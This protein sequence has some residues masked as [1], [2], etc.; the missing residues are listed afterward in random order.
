MGNKYLTKQ[1]SV[2]QQNN[3][4]FRPSI[5]LKFCCIKLFDLYF[6]EAAVQRYSVKTVFLGLRPATLLK[7][8]LQH[9]CFPV[10]FAKFLRTPFFKEHLWWLL[11][12]FVL[13]PS[14]GVRQGRLGI[15]S[16]N[17]PTTVS[18]DVYVNYYSDMYLKHRFIFRHR[19]EKTS[20]YPQQAMKFSY[21][22]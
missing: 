20:Y 18:Y 15:F 7:R 4:F 9:S 21:C 12:T 11:L 10:N 19:L 8:K 1:Y 14:M 3:I 22:Y 5:I 13:F 17:N 6:S 16:K 2:L